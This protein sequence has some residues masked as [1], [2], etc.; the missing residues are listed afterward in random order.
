MVCSKPPGKNGTCSL[1]LRM[2]W[3]WMGGVIANQ[4]S[5]SLRYDKEIGAKG[6]W[7]SNWCET[8]SLSPDR[9]E[10]K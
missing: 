4:E 1:D 7:L 8:A 9:P 5:R 10:G 6:K 3:V 2:F